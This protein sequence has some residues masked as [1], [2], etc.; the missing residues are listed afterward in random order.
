MLEPRLDAGDFLLNQS[1]AIADYLTL[2]DPLAPEYRPTV[3][4][5]YHPCDAA[6]LSLHELAG[7]NWHAQQRQ[8]LLEEDISDGVDALGVLLMGHPRGVFTG[9]AHV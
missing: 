5:A 9:T 3:L 8:R 4:Y 7:R 1:I 6:V 2:G